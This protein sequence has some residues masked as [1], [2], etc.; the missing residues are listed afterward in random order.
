MKQKKKEK[1]QKGDYGYLA[2]QRKTEIIK[3]VL[4]FAISIAVYITGYISSGSRENL[5]TVV[6]VLGLLPASKSTVSVIM[7]LRFQTGSREVYEKISKAAGTMPVFYDSVI[8]TTQKSY[9]VNAFF[10]RGA[11]LC[12]YTEKTD[13]DV[14]AVE[15]HIREMLYVN[16]LKKVTVKLYTNLDAYLARMDA[17]RDIETE[18]IINDDG[19]TREEQVIAL[20]RSLSL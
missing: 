1:I 10:C 3:T 20:I 5:F 11:N 12:G 19:V 9:P 6:A 17:L 14:K 15:K 16:Q 2:S 4:L 8:T 18:E 7:F 13:A